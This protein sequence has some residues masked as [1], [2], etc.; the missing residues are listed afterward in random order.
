[1]NLGGVEALLENRPEAGV[2]VLSPTREPLVLG[3]A[4]PPDLRPEHVPQIANEDTES[5]FP[6]T[7]RKIWPIYWLL[8][9]LELNH[10][11]N[12]CSPLPR[13]RLSVST[14][15]LRTETC[16][17]GRFLYL[18]LLPALLLVLSFAFSLFSLFP[19]CWGDIFM[20]AS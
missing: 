14:T 16:G 12:F 13:C 5:L 18:Y 15:S 19:F 10:L 7:T 4:P 8:L 9:L 20:A 2:T 3:Q 1:M 6:W 17:R 11:L